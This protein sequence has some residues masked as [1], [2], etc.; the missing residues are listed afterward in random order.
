MWVPQTRTHGGFQET[1]DTMA[2]FLMPSEIEKACLPCFDLFPHS[3]GTVMAP[4]LE[5]T[6][7][8]AAVSLG[9]S[10]WGCRTSQSDCAFG[11]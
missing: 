4:S 1:R 3:L 11:V 8:S 2:G 10:V 5:W 9:S 6:Q 7:D